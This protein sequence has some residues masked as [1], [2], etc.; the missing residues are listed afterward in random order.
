MKDSAEL[1]E[2]DIDPSPEQLE[3]MKLLVRQA[4]NEG[5]LGLGSSMIYAPA[6]YAETL[7]AMEARAAAIAA[8]MKV[9]AP[10]ARA[11]LPP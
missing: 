2:D 5:A 8:V 11:D 3:R 10:S 4:M 1:G 7:T 9:V 6:A